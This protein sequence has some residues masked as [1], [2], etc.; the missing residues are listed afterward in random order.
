M[1][2]PIMFGLARLTLANMSGIPY[3]DSLISHP[4]P[5]LFPKS[6]SISKTLNSLSNKTTSTTGR[7]TGTS[8]LAEISAVFPFENPARAE[9]PAI[10]PVL[11]V[12]RVE[13]LQGLGREGRKPNFFFLPPRPIT[14]LFPPPA[15]GHPRA[16]V[17][18]LR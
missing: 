9:V 2:K 18:L 7:G 16:P 15:A 17:Q 5:Y 12:R 10:G 11:P 8:G 1:E 13:E 14:F 4:K 3:Y 6:H